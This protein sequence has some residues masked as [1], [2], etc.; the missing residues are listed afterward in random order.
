MSGLGD[1]L[2]G[3][4]WSKARLAAESGVSVKTIGR[5]LS[6]QV[7]PSGRT[8][9]HVADALGEP[10][11]RLVSGL[12]RTPLDAALSVGGWTTDRLARHAGV[13]P[14]TIGYLRAGAHQ[15]NPHTARVIAGALGLRI[16]DLFPDRVVPTRTPFAAAIAGSGFSQRELARHAGVGITTIESWAA[17]AATPRA[18]KAG[19]VARVLGK[20]VQELFTVTTGHD[21][22]PAAAPMAGQPLPLLAAGDV[23]AARASGQRDWSQRAL[24]ASGQHDPELWWPNSGDDGLA[25]RRACA[26][27]PVVG[28]CR[29]HFLGQPTSGWKRQELDRGI[30]AGLPGG[31]LRSAAC[32]HDQPAGAGPPI[33][34]SRAVE[35]LPEDRPGR[36]YYSPTAG[37]SR[38]RLE[39]FLEAHDLS[40]A[41][42]ARLAGIRARTLSQWA[43]G[44]RTPTPE[45]ARLLAD[46]FGVAAAD[47]F[48]HV[49]TQPHQRSAQPVDTADRPDGRPRARGRAA[50]R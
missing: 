49:N 48:E 50:C 20:P 1:A 44:E 32:G 45:S 3:R 22:P 5:W 36:G 21:L 33:A 30:W 8:V 35:R 26:G 25:A 47:L 9:R 10:V 14:D 41:D 37:E 7:T 23:L 18:D 34:V 29:D 27:C 6:G 31:E 11:G 28:D 19:A 2:A 38:T 46:A 15:P 39:R 16:A 4:G 12:P 43:R 17:G 13:S 24:C 42:A 40:N